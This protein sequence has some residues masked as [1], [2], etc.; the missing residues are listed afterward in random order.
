M[1]L[2]DIVDVVISATTATP[3]RTGFGTPLIA[4]YHTKYTDR[5]RT[6]NKPN[7]LL[8]DGFLV[9]DDAYLAATALK[10]QNP[11]VKSFK[12]G[13]LALTTTDTLTLQVLDATVGDAVTFDLEGHSFDYAIVLPSFLAASGDTLTVAGAAKTLTR[14]SGSWLADG[15]AIGQDVSKLKS[16]NAYAKSFA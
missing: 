6:Y 2:S 13:R 10:A 8:G 15:F 5:V 4:A 11:S 1:A 16:S 14:S 7:D 9:S 3:T 12:L